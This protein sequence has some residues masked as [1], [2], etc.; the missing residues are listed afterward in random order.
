MA[1]SIDG[2][3]VMKI[4]MLR[5]SLN[6]GQNRTRHTERGKGAQCNG[7]KRKTIMLFNVVQTRDKHLHHCLTTA[8]K[9]CSALPKLHSHSVV[10]S[11]VGSFVIFYSVIIGFISM[12]VY[13]SFRFVVH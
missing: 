12:I 4:I 3:N 8:V 2:I 7:P 5:T 13:S 1:I 11:V 6:D 9:R 10:R